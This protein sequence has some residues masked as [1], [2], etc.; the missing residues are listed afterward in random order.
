M[1]LSELSCVSQEA[2]C[3]VIERTCRSLVGDWEGEPW[4]DLVL[5]RK[6]QPTARLASH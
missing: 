3:P 4:G 2:L 5:G 1:A 6:T